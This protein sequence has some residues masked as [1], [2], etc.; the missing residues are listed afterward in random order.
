[1]LVELEPVAEL[2]E[3]ALMIGQPEPMV[4]IARPVMIALVVV[5]VVIAWPV[6]L[7]L[8]VVPAMIVE[9]VV[10]CIPS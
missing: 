3:Y 2:V 9:P 6:V 4:A 8:V 5:P 10:M 1:M 7:V